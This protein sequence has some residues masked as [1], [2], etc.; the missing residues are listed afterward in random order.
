MEI[1]DIEQLA[2]S[3]FNS[4]SQL[5]KTIKEYVVFEAWDL[6][7]MHSKRKLAEGMSIMIDEYVAYIE[8]LLNQAGFASDDATRKLYIDKIFINWERH[9]R[10]SMPWPVKRERNEKIYQASELNEIVKMEKEFIS[11]GKVRHMLKLLKNKERDAQKI[12]DRLERA[13]YF[14]QQVKEMMNQLQLMCHKARKLNGTKLEE[15][16]TKMQEVMNDFKSV[17]NNAST[18]I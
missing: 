17:E 6:S 14:E 1:Q 16:I 7:I 13:Q 11:I 8:M 15:M 12:D 5:T 10:Y 3:V 4:P 18:Q 2:T 9:K